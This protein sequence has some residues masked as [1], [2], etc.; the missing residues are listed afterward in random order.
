ME[1]VLLNANNHT[2]SISNYRFQKIFGE[3]IRVSETVRR[4]KDGAH[5]VYVI[6]EETDK[7][8]FIEVTPDDVAQAFSHFS[9]NYTGRQCVICDLQGENQWDHF[10]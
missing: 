3:D 8:D 7:E 4:Q 2:G 10:E 9:Y 6:E 5:D 1:W